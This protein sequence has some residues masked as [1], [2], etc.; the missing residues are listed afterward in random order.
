VRELCVAHRDGAPEGYPVKT[1][2]LKRSAQSLWLLRARTREGAVWLE[3]RPAKGIWAG[4]YCLPVFESRDA[5]QAALP[6][7]TR[8]HDDEP[9]VHVLT[10]KDLHLHP[11]GVELAGNSRGVGE[12]GW[13]GAG[14]L[15]RLG[16][17]APIRRLLE[18]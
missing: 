8:L 5:L 11:V 17:P 16:L 10:H 13:F 9:F 4:L 3:K 14:D 6:A 1:R 2:K 18:S 15:A 7:K 12:G